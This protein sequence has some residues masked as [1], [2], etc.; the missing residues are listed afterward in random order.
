MG[1]VSG[2][3]VFVSGNNGRLPCN[4]ISCFPHRATFR[5]A[6]KSARL[7]L[8]LWSSSEEP[9]SIIN[10]PLL[11][12]TSEKHFFSWSKGAGKVRVVVKVAVILNS[13]KLLPMQR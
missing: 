3:E 13:A 4:W 12:R 10:A 11:E 7:A 6:K 9:G 2:L 5:I 8:E 1:T